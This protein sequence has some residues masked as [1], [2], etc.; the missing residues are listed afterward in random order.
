MKK[1]ISMF[2]PAYNEERNIPEII[3]KAKKV[4]R[5]VADKY[6]II[7]VA[8]EGS[9]DNTINIVKQ[10]A[11]KDGHVR[12]IPQPKGKKGVGYAKILGFKNAQYPYIFYADADL[13]F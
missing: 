13:Q 1:N 12:L 7:I 5:D 11:K 2:F 4:L 6:E 9:T 10:S 3:K 8:Y